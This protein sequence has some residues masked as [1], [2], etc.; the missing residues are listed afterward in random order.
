MYIKKSFKIFFKG[1]FQK[2]FKKF[3]KNYGYFSTIFSRIK[4]FFA[5][6]LDLSKNDL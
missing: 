5:Y 1:F 4:F 3:L 2:Y 6:Y